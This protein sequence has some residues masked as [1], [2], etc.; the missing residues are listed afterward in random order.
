MA[1]TIL[2]IDDDET[3]VELVRL[4]LR[5]LGF[6]V[7]GARNGEQG[8]GLFHELGPDLVTLDVLMPGIDGW[9][10]CRRLRNVSSVPIMFLTVLDAEQ[11]VVRG[12]DSGADDYLSKPFQVA[13]LRA[14][15]AALLRR[16]QPLPLDGRD[17]SAPPS[18]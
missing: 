17:R 11:N 8:L 6:E 16:S 15:V 1:P 3:M 12:L 5:K 4:S 14:R 18:A 10:V 9:E 7:V 13:E 2:V